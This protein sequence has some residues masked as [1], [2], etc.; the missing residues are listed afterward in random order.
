MRTSSESRTRAARWLALAGLALAASCRTTRPVERPASPATGVTVV[1]SMYSGRPD[2]T[3]VLDDTA[4]IVELAA[5]VR[6]AAP[7][8]EVEGV[9]VLRSV[10]G[11]RGVIVRNPSGAGG[12]P[13]HLM[14]FDGYIEVGG[15]PP[16]F[17][18]D[19]GGRAESRLI[20]LAVTR[21]A[22][23]EDELRLIRRR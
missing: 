13:R 3:F 7:A 19:E 15:E 23:G 9:S 8:P 20:D 12:R 2:P 11:Y 6:D 21:K 16:C 5:W 22:I 10:L 1:V 4:A 14:V 17:L 18:K